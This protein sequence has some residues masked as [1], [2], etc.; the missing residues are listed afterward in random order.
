MNKMGAGN[1]HEIGDIVK[2]AG[3]IYVLRNEA[4]H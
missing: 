3:W 2:L 4:D 1:F